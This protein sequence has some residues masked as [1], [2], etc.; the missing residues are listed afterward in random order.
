[1][2]SRTNTLAVTLCLLSLLSVCRPAFAQLHGVFLSRPEA[3]EFQR[4]RRANSILEELRLGNLEREC[5][6]ERCSYE[7]ASEIFTV[8]ERLNEFWKTYSDEDLCESGPCLNGGSCVD[9]PG[10]YICIC[11]HGFLG[12]NCGKAARTSCG[13][14]Y[15][16]GGCE[17]FCT[18]LPDLSPYCH[19]APD[20]ALGSDNSSCLPQVP[21]PCGRTVPSL[22]PRIIGGDVCPKGQC[23]W[24]AMLEYEEAYKCGGIVLD[25]QW[26]LTA[27]HCVWQSN[28]DRFQVTV[29]EHDRQTKE[30]TEQTRRVARVLV[31]PR[32]NHATKDCDLAL[33]RLRGPVAL[34]PWVVPACLPPPRGASGHALAGVRSSAVSGWGRVAP[35]GP[36]SA[37]LKR[38]EVPTVR[39][40]DCREHS[41]LNVTRNM[42]CAGYRRGVNDACQGDS[43]GP[44]VTLYRDTWF[45]TG[46][47]SWGKGCA[48]EGRYGVYTRVA[49]FLDWIDATRATG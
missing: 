25:P 28:A 13:C 18:E 40:Q 12:R 41:G 35:S 1:M 5:L 2:E 27:A 43:G 38:L 34:G 42:L 7:E 48:Q 47:V 14:L 33:L 39:L 17:H 24:Q 30:G 4:V 20:Y 16:N 10:T 32:Y 45:L 37:L 8:P 31:H 9:Q 49:N 29:G 6:E 22:G 44:L 3:N 36:P 23:P 15:R 26:I 21:F 19:C 11:R 46:V